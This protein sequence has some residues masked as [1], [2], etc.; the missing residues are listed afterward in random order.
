M[1]FFIT[2][3]LAIQYHEI[4]FFDISQCLHLLNN[5]TLLP[6]IIKTMTDYIRFHQ[7]QSIY[8]KSQHLYDP[9]F[10]FKCNIDEAMVPYKVHF[11][12]KQYIPQ[13]PTK[14]DL[15]LWMRADSHQWVCIWASNV[16][17]KEKGSSECKVGERVIKDL[18][19]KLKCK[20]DHFFCDNF[21]PVSQ[22]S[23]I[24]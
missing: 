23:E 20:S 22:S 2:I 16:C 19:R 15:K 5:S 12:M 1:N 24:C 17:N 21:S 7:S 8:D 18:M 6:Q 10:H 11:S 3:Q 9:C 14:G 4:N 13:K